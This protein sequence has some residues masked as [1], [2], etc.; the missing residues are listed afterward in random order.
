M[1]WFNF[2]LGINFIFLCFKLIIIHYR[3][4]KQR[5]IQMSTKD[6]SELQDIYF[7]LIVSAQ[8]DDLQAFISMM[9]M[10]LKIDLFK[11]NVT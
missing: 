1:L 7:I 9:H 10:L 4:Q 2:I 6:K 8:Q 11:K 3:T 5:K